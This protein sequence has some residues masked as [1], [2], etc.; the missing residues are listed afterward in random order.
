M[1]KKGSTKRTGKDRKAERAKRVK[2]T[3]KIWEKYKVEGDKLVRSN[4]FSPKSPGDFLANHKNRKT[5]GKTSYTE[6]ASKAKT[7]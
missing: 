3:R 6:F 2:K 1:A 7:E 4:Q 5:C